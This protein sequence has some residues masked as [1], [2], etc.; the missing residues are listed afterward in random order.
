MCTA[1]MPQHCRRTCLKHSEAWAAAEYVALCQQCV[2]KRPAI[3]GAPADG[4]CQQSARRS[5]QTLRRAHAGTVLLVARISFTVHTAH[6]RGD[7]ANAGD[8]SLTQSQRQT[9]QDAPNT[10]CSHA[11]APALGQPPRR[12]GSHTSRCRRRALA[13]L[14]LHDA[15][16]ILEDLVRR[17]APREGRALHRVD[18]VLHHADYEFL[19]VDLPRSSSQ[20]L[21]ASPGVHAHT[22]GCEVCAH[23]AR[24]AARA[25]VPAAVCMCGG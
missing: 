19:S 20:L 21:P 15:R 17:L 1:A 14:R 13:R 8:T 6:A 25:T 4:V 5:F 11:Y 10:P 7:A 23:C 16:R 22:A 2:C 12:T 9:R 18:V 3:R 24:R